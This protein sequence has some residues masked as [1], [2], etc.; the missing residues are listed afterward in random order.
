MPKTA[1]VFFAAMSQLQPILQHASRFAKL[2]CH[3]QGFVVGGVVRV[4]KVTAGQCMF[5]RDWVNTE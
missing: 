5:G 3:T 2:V 4:V 1:G